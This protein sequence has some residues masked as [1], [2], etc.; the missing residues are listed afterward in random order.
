MFSNAMAPAGV[1]AIER[2]ESVLMVLRAPPEVRR[3]TPPRPAVKYT[4]PSAPRASWPTPFGQAPRP[5]RRVEMVPC[6]EMVRM[7]PFPVSA[8]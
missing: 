7:R 4:D 6:G 1:T 3:R 2:A 5:A 8:R